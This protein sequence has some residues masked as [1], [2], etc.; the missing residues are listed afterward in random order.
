M[1]SPKWCGRY[2]FKYLRDFDQAVT[3]KVHLTPQK[4]T[5]R[6]RSRRPVYCFFDKAYISWSNFNFRDP[7]FWFRAF[8]GIDSW[9]AK[10]DPI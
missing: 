4:E 2:H 6:L 3:P 7:W 8:G 5:D 9:E 1:I 10:R